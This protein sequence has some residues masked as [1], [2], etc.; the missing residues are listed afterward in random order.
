MI[1]IAPVPLGKSQGIKTWL[2]ASI[3]RAD[4][5]EINSYLDDLRPHD[6]FTRLSGDCPK[7]LNGILGAEN[8]SEPQLNPFDKKKRWSVIDKTPSDEKWHEVVWKQ[9]DAS[10]FVDALKVGD[11][12]V[13]LVRALVR[14]NFNWN[15]IRDP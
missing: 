7:Y 2:E 10:G 11:R 4:D 13:L 9:G 6:W 8:V 15:C 12:I 3:L 5:P 1:A 14:P